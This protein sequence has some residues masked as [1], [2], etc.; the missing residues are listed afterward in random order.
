MEIHINGGHLGFWMKF[1]FLFCPC[2]FCDR[3][4]PNIENRIKIGSVVLEWKKYKQARRKASMETARL[5][6]FFLA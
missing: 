3:Y 2:H 4:G 1:D 5:D 6:A